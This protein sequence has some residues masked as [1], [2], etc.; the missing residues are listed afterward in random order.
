MSVAAM[1]AVVTTKQLL[2][3]PED[4]MER[5]LIRG[6]LKERPMSCRGRLHS[7]ITSKLDRLLGKWYEQ[8]PEPRGE[9]LTGEQAF[10][11]QH[12]PDTTVGIDLAYIA[13]DLAASVPED[14]FLIDGLPVLAVEVLSPSDMIEDVADKV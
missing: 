5:E 11:L 3:M 6:Q 12:D 13:P 14:V 2:A 9:L 7:R 4:G 10:R 1:P 8:L